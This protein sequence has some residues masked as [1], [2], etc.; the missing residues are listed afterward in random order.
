MSDMNRRQHERHTIDWAAGYRLDGTGEWLPCRAV[1]MGQ[2]GVAIE[3]PGLTGAEY[4]LGDIEV[5]FELAGADAFDLRGVIRH[6]AR[7]HRGDVL[8][9]VEFAN[10]STE[11][12]ALLNALRT[13]SAV[14]A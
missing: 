12:L 8:F 7:S 6:R 2:G 9:G 3:A 4:L 14:P 1:N 13:T 5:R 10:L 11:D